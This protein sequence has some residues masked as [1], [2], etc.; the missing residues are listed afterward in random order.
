MRTIGITVHHTEIGYRLRHPCQRIQQHPALEPK[1]R[2]H[3]YEP[4]HRYE[5][6]KS[7]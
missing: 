2:Q 6:R 5:K 4:D 7:A 1:N 3:E